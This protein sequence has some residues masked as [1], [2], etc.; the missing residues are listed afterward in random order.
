MWFHREIGR[1]GI[2]RL[3][4]ENAR[5]AT[6]CAAFLLNEFNEIRKTRGELKFCGPTQL[7]NQRSGDLQHVLSWDF[8]TCFCQWFAAEQVEL[9]S[10]TMISSWIAD[11]AFCS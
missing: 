7:I 5:S 3:N 8:A 4:W 6:M 11:I 9:N 2:C 10:N 1:T